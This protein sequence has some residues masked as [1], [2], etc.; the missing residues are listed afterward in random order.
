MTQGLFIVVQ[1]FLADPVLMPPMGM[2]L[3]NY[4]DDVMIGVP[5]KN[6]QITL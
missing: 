4:I 1:A 2:F 5:Q 3:Q 6:N